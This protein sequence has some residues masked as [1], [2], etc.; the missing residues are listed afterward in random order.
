MP[1]P[2]KPT[3]QADLLAKWKKRKS[4]VA[5]AIPARPEGEVVRPTSGQKRLW[6]LQRLHPGN[7]FYQYGHLYEL[8]G[9]LRADLLEESFRRLVERHEILRTNY[10][11][12]EANDVEMITRPAGPFHL[13]RL[14]PA[15]ETGHDPRAAAQ[16]SADAFA[17]RPFDLAE[18][19]LMRA[20]LISFGPDRHYLVVCLHHII[21]DRGSLL[22]FNQEL[23]RTY[24]AL[25]AE[26]EPAL[27]T[28]PA[29][30]SDYAHW[31]NQRPT[32][33]KSLDYWAEELADAP[34][35]SALPADRARRAV[36]G[37]GGQTLTT[38]LDPDVARRVKDLARACGTT[39]NVVLLA[40]YLALHPR[41]AAQKDIAVGTPVSI[42]DRTELENMFGFLNETVVI[43]VRFD[44]PD[45]T[46]RALVLR[47]KARMEA[48]LEHKA[49]AF[50]EV[51]GHLR[52]ERT[53]GANPLFQNMFV[54]NAPAPEAA[55]PRG[56]TVTDEMMDLGVAKFD[57]TLFATDL[58]FTFDFA[59][60][61]A[62]DLFDEDTAGR[63]L[64]NQLALITDA[65]DRPDAP[66]AELNVFG[67]PER[68]LRENW[69]RTDTEFPRPT[70]TMVERILSASRVNL[71][72]VAVTDATGLL[73]YEDLFGRADDLARQLVAKGTRP[74]D[75]VGLSVGRSVD[76]AVGILGI[77]MAGGAYVPLDP[78]YPAGRIAFVTEDAGIRLIVTQPKLH[79]LFDGYD[80][81]DIPTTDAGGNQETEL[82]VLKSTDPAYLIYTSGSTGRPKGVVISHANLVHSTTARFAYF[83][84]EPSVF[85][86]LSSFAF[87][88]SVAGIFW[89]LSKGGKLVIPPERSEQDMEGLAGLIETHRVS[90]TLLLPSL[91]QLLLEQARPGRL[92]SLKTVMVAGEACGPSVVRRHFELLPGVE[93]VNEYGPTEGTVWCTAHRVEPQDAETGVPIGRPIPNVKNYVLDERLREVPIGVTG[94]LYIAGPGLATGY[95]RRPELT[96]ERFPTALLGADAGATEGASKRLYRTGDLARRRPSGL[97]DFLGRAD[98][99]VKI[100]GHRVEPGEIS[101]VL[102][103]RAGVREAVTL[104]DQS[105]AAPRLLAYFTA[106]ESITEEQLRADLRAELPAYM[107]PSAF[108]FL[109]AFPRL[110]NGKVDVSAL[111]RP[112]T[113][114][115]TERTF[116]APRT[117]TERTLAEL[118]AGV[119]KLD[120][121][122]RNDNYFDLGGDSIRSI[123]IISRA[124]KAG[125]ELSPTHLF[126]YPVLQDLA[127]ALDAER[128]GEPA[129]SDTDATV[130]RLNDEGDGEPLFCVHSGGGHVFFYQPLA[131]HLTGKRPVYAVQPSTLTTGEELPESIEA[132]AAGYLAAIKKVRPHGPYHLLGTCFSNVVVLEIAQQ[133]IAAGDEV[134][135][136]IFVDSGP[137]RLERQPEVKNPVA[138]NAARILLTGNWKKLRRAIYR[139]WFYVKQ[140]FGATVET[141]EGKQVRLI[142]NAL[143]QLYFEYDWLPVDAAVT[144]IR[145]TEF[146]G[147]ADKEFHLTQWQKL[148]DR[149]LDVRVTEGTHLNL[150][151][152]PQAE[153]LAQNVE[154]CLWVATVR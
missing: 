101:R 29:Q 21:G 6:L 119:L 59:L 141:E 106:D 35:L 102:D 146:A 66:L 96:A 51:V 79:E 149:G 98:R 11:G 143:Y 120:R 33:G 130:V 137:T 145:S 2:K 103:R 3:S 85:L 10:V 52:P 125:L 97:I 20:A 37:N 41:Y 58:G 123:R 126:R 48:A 112:E 87:D 49:A 28:L 26:T 95:W 50:E 1:D 55:L 138:R 90:H 61:Y 139:R 86:L 65:A 118:W 23:Y 147:R 24:A 100:R 151:A 74:G 4:P 12:T 115:G 13:H 121:I 88:S 27:P 110:P 129:G 62:T 67:E 114:G 68:E 63:L 104:I 109:A 32:P 154:E 89:T 16:R 76:L 131:A 69:N 113:G 70:T 22:V 83:K 17:R 144:L 9:P 116:V 18:G 53:P 136:L 135:R 14:E 44:D 132:M 5:R 34:P 92:A 91:Y 47:V 150:F 84:H 57:L 117:D 64:T 152:N 78:A 77:L 153:G 124:R 71:G 8:N 80:L 134:G 54:Y 30:F 94:E 60:E 45:E 111:P 75:F 25:M 122:S 142:T 93:L 56:L 19:R 73:T 81:L 46:F 82:P 107:M 133:L 40:A 108:V 38:S 140:A 127:A 43:R 72:T 42:R 15:V 31:A 36:G 105:G 99:Q 128:S 148:A 39:T 7:A